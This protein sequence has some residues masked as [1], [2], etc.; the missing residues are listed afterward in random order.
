M[1]G[2]FRNPPL[3]E[4]AHQLRSY[5]RMHLPDIIDFEFLNGL[6]DHATT[7]HPPLTFIL[8][9]IQTSIHFSRFSFV[10]WLL[11]LRSNRTVVG[12]EYAHIEGELFR[13]VSNG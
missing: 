6:G 2:G 7:E 11:W 8:S 4:F 5:I 3:T 10:S 12:V 13:L 9:H 1:R